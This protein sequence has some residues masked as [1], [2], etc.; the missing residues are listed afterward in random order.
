VVKILENKEMEP[1]FVAGDSAA[2]FALELLL[3]R[4]GL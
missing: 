1:F 2:P 4:R 3:S